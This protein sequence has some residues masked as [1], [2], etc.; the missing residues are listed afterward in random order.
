MTPIPIEYLE[1]C[2]VVPVIRNKTL[3]QSAK[4]AP[5]DSPRQVLVWPTD[6]GDGNA[7]IT[8]IPKWIIPSWKPA[9]A[10]VF[11]NSVNMAPSGN[12]GQAQVKRLK[13]SVVKEPND[14]HRTR[15]AYAADGRSAIAGIPFR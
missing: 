9:I 10:I 8:I 1:Q 13:S 12:D 2:L 5:Q 6:C 3:L 15:V 4:S 7:M 11:D 14:E